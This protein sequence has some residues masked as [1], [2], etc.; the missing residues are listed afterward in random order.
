MNRIDKNLNKYVC[1]LLIS[2][3]AVHFS[4]TDKF[5][6]TNANE[7]TIDA[8]SA[9]QAVELVNSTYN[10]LL[11]WQVSSFSWNAISSIASDDADKGSDPGD[12]G[13]D[14]HLF[15]ILA[16]DATSISIAEVW[17]GHYNGIQRAN[18]AI[19]RIKLFDDLDL[20]LRH[21]LIGEAKFLRAL[22]YFRLVQT[23]G[24]VP[25]ITETPDVNSPI[26]T[27]L[28]RA[29]KNEVFEFI[30]N[31][32]IESINVLPEKSTYADNQLGRATIGAAKTLLAKV[33]LYQNKWETVLELTN[34][35]I[36][37]GEYNLTPNY[38]DIWKE[39][40]ENNEESIFEIQAKG[41]L[42]SVG[43]DQYSLTQGARGVGGWG[44]GFNVP[45]E[46]LLNSY[47]PN[48]LRRD[49]TI[50]FRGETLYDGRFVPETVV[51]P[52]Y[53][54]KA[55]SSAF[56]D[57]QQTGKN[58]RI[59]RYA[60][61]LLMNAEAASQLGG[62]VAGP[63]NQVR[64]RAGLESV[65]N[66]SQTDVWNERRWELAFEHDRYFDLVRQGRAATVLQSLGIPFKVGKHELFP[67]P[68][69]Q[70]N[71]SDGILKQNPGWE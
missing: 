2:V 68:Q 67:I 69:V 59:L 43:V 50:I 11:S 58:I 70:I 46:N 61:V 71:L 21:R 5:L 48:D 52:M 37:S 42:P 14:K 38:E 20:E 47:D 30:E 19:N 23:Y 28:R 53:N 64:N 31:D 35:V 18:Q 45:S 39:V 57:Y 60:E 44:W 12:T 8:I 24:G 55:Y 22:F 6:E 51:N 32:L 29:S 40:G 54:Q 33:S 66:P 16:H 1:C 63:L 25:I 4:C 34:D 49:A 10:I 36:K 65:N 26:E 3:S 15:D 9:E 62:D 7:I 56:T 17:E 41:E 13:A 27:L